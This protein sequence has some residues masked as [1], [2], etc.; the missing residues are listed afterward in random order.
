MEILQLKSTFPEMKH[1]LAEMKG[2][3]LT[4]ENRSGH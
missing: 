3:L 2:R 4:E 1:S